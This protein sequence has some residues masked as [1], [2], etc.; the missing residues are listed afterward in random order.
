[1]KNLWENNLNFL[2]D[3]TIIYVKLTTYVI[4]VFEKK[5]E[6]VN[7]V[8]PLVPTD[9]R[10]QELG[11]HHLTLFNMQYTKDLTGARDQVTTN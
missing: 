6:G 7:F 1:M 2:N 4:T 5:R 10:C 3:V 9:V 11:G 8:P